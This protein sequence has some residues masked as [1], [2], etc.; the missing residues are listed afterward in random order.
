MQAAEVPEH[1]EAGAQPEVEGVAEDDLG[2]HRLERL[3]R[4]ALDAAIG[5][6]RHEDRRLDRAVDQAEAAAPRQAFGG[7]DVEGK[8]QRIVT[9]VRASSIASP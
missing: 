9:G 8:H 2:A 1:V 6:D 5:A 4:D 3:R 7:E